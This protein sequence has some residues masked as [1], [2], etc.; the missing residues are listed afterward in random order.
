[1]VSDM[2]YDKSLKQVIERITKLIAEYERRL[3]EKDFETI[4]NNSRHQDYQ[5]VVDLAKDYT[6]YSTGEGLDEKLEIFAPSETP[7]MHKQRV[8]LTIVNTADILNSCVKPLNK[9]GRTPAM[10]H[11]VWEGKDAMTTAENK[12]KILKIGDH[13]WGKQSVEKYLEKRMAQFDKTDCNS[14]C[15]IEF[16]VPLL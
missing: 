3:K 12:R 14:F 8:N 4:K 7:E 15:V 5:H 10:K 16:K 1:M 13:F 2:K 9:V 6:I 11:F